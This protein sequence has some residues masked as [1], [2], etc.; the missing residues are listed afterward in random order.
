MTFQ[1]SLRRNHMHRWALAMLATITWFGP[2][3]TLSAMAAHPMAD[4][5]SP[6]EDEPK[7]GEVAEKELNSKQDPAARQVP[8]GSGETK[9]D[10]TTNRRADQRAQDDDARALKF[11]ELHQPELFQLLTY[12][13]TK[14]PKQYQ[15][16]MRD[17]GR[18]AL[19]LIQLRERDEEMYAIELNLWQTRC[20]LRL[21]AAEI[22]VLEDPRKKNK[23][24]GQLK[25]LVELELE[26]EQSRASLQRQRVARQLER[27]DTQIQK[28]EQEKDARVTRA[29][30]L[31]Q[32]R[33]NKQRSDAGKSGSKSKTTQQETDA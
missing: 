16:A 17:I 8:Q 20:K 3:A 26:Q 23:A 13:R 9:P 18:A 7:R 32:N 4:E 21:L 24:E 5:V 22:S 33:I 29:L 10:S 1:A 6:S 11:V 30:K 15:E 27:L 12:L 31:W 19:R 2:A 14:N 28:N 25:Q